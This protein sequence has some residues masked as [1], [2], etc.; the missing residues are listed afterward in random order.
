MMNVKTA[1]SCFFL[2]LFTC[3]TLQAQSY[4]I[5]LLVGGSNYTGDLSTGLVT[6]SESHLAAGAY[7]M[8]PMNRFLHIRLT[9]RYG[10]ISGDDAK[11]NDFKRMERNLSFRSRI[12]EGSIQLLVEPLGDKFPISPYLFA[13]AA[14]YHFNPKAE[15]Q[16]EWID[17]QPLGT[18][19][20]GI[21]NGKAQKYGLT[22]LAFPFG[23]GIRW[24]T[25]NNWVLGLEASYHYTFTDYL[26]DVSTVYFSQEQLIAKN[27]ELSAALA[28]RSV[29]LNPDAAPITAGFQR[30]NPE[31]KDVYLFAGLTVGYRLKAKVSKTGCYRF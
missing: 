19:G 24:A 11:S 10:T 15:Y 4:E 1:L 31:V 29:E 9:A 27:G 17:L 2:V 28:D 20:Q 21:I 14:V 25:K 12:Y 3:L 23:G 7:G 22:G 26:D 16:G 8:L 30:G 6:Y 13:G 5:G 18:E